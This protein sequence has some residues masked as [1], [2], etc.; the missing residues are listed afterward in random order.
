MSGTIRMGGSG[1]SGSELRDYRSR[2]TRRMTVPIYIG[3]A[4]AFLSDVSFEVFMLFGLFYLP[5]ICTAVF[6]SNPRSPWYLACLATVLITI[7][8]FFPI[9]N[10]DTVVAIINRILSIA[11]IFL[12]AAL[13]RHAR[14]IQDRLAEQTARAEAAER[15]KTEMFTTLSTEFRQP[16]QGLAAVAGVMMADCRPDQREP[17]GRVQQHAE[18]LSASINNL[19]DLMELPDHALQRQTVDIDHIL[20]GAMEAAYVLARSRQITLVI[21]QDEPIPHLANS[22]PWA[23]RRIVDNLVTNAV[24]YSPPGSVV[25]LG[26]ETAPQ[27]IVISVR[28]TGNGIPDPVLRRLGETPQSDEAVLVRLGRG[29]G[30]GLAL[31]RGLARAMGAELHFDSE[32]GSGTTVTLLLPA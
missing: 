31:C 28:D 16:L 2:W 27:G 10:P 24:K 15:L 23:V 9:I 6:H 18:R 32:A 20:R 3:C 21:D 11:A 7:G 19:I 8:F 17:L 4:L 14:V 22:D 30:T 29:P 25:E 5:L 1:L 12:T 26:V 13:V